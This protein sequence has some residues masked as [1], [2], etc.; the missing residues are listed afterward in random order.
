MYFKFVQLGSV[1]KSDN[2]KEMSKKTWGIFN[3]N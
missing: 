3:A 2:A 1:I